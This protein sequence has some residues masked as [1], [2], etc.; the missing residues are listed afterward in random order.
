LNH[1]AKAKGVIVT[2]HRRFIQF[3]Q[4]IAMP[5]HTLCNRKFIK[6]HQVEDIV[7]Q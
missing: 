7:Q 6:K 4:E 3:V 2:A 5:T 1:F